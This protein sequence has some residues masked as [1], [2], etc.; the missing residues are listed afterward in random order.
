MKIAV[1]LIGLLCLP[2]VEACTTGPE[3]GTASNTQLNI[4]VHV[5]F[6]GTLL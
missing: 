6:A 4:L 1:S 2:L 5:E 3:G